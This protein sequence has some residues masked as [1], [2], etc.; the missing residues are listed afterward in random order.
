MISATQRIQTVIPNNSELLVQ[1]NRNRMPVWN[2]CAVDCGGRV[3][4]LNLTRLVVLLIH[5][6]G[7]D[8]VLYTICCLERQIV[9]NNTDLAPGSYIYP[10]HVWLWL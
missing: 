3:I 8:P 10:F 4:Q 9:N 5:K 2:L 6:D 1:S 7:V